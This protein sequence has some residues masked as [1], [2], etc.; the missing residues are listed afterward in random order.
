[1]HARRTRRGEN[2]PVLAFASSKKA[3]LDAQNIRSTYIDIADGQLELGSEWDIDYR[4]HL[5]RAKVEAPPDK[6]FADTVTVL[7]CYDEYVPP[8]H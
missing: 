8:V 4:D 3:I 2:R 6:P 7:V 5:W 1:M